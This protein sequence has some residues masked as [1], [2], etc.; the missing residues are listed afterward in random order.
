MFLRCGPSVPWALTRHDLLQGTK[1][2]V[3]LQLICKQ[4]LNLCKV[5]HI[6]VRGRD[7][8]VTAGHI[9]MRGKG[10]ARKG[11]E[12]HPFWGMPQAFPHRGAVSNYPDLSPASRLTPYF[13]RV[14][15]RLLGKPLMST[16][17]KHPFD[18]P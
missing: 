8:P 9:M 15:T 1:L 2:R 17:T 13:L 14:M 5:F 10:W 4:P 16:A 6:L 3:F 7:A 11:A 18:N 12:T